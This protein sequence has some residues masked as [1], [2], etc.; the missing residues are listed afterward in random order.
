M[1][2]PLACVRIQ[3]FPSNVVAFGM[4]GNARLD[5]FAGSA[6]GALREGVEPPLPRLRR[7]LRQQGGFVRKRGA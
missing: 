4:E 5:F 2:V 3:L 7:R 1:E 6:A